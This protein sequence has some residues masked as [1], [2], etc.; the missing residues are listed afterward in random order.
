M[1][2]SGWS[3]AGR[4]KGGAEASWARGAIDRGIGSPSL[5]WQ[6]AIERRGIV[7]ST[8]WGLS[9]GTKEGGRMKKTVSREGKVGPP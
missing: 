8:R 7:K 1:S 5:K 9:R 3:P 4:K 2:G 6:V